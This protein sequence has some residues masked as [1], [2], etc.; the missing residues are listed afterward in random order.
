MQK[1]VIISIVIAMIGIIVIGCKKDEKTKV[2]LSV[3]SSLKDPILKIEEIYEK[4]NSNVDLVLNF[5][6]SGSLKQQ[7]VQGAPCEIFISASKKYMDE[8]KDENYL[9]DNKYTDLVRNKL[10]LVSS[11][12]DIHSIE[13]LK[14]EEYKRIGIG[15]VKTVPVGQYAEEVIVNTGIKP[16][17][18]DKLIYGKDA[19][20]VLAWVISGNVDAGF[21]YLSDTTHHRNLNT[22]NID[23]NL[24]ST[25]IYPIGV[26][27]KG[28]NLEEASNIVK[29][30]QSEESKKIL[31]SYG[32]VS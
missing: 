16:Y 3:A 6:S 13:D 21:L 14:S 22:V 23:D 32:Y 8:L 10:V 31:E 20:E 9:L 28:N 26:M 2:H 15:E 30:L 4:N 25:I 18:E 24:H 19:K 1:K 11:T 17:V 12:K 7:I 5:G 27:K 29:F